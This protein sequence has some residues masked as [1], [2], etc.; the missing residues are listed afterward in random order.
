MEITRKKIAVVFGTRPDAVALAP[1]I[2]ELR[3]YPHAVSLLLINAA[4]Q[5]DALD[6]I[7]T[8]YSITPDYHVTVMGNRQSL[9]TLAQHILEKMDYLLAMEQPDMV[10]VR[11][12]AITA[13]VAGLA[14][15]HRKI[16]VVHVDAGLRSTDKLQPFPGEIYRRLTAQM[17]DLHC[18][19]TPA[20]AKAL[21]KEGIAKKS[22]VC[23]GNPAID[24]L[25]MTVKPRFEFTSPALTEV[26]A[27]KRRIIVVTTH[28]RENRGEP[29]LH[30]CAA[31]KELAEQ[32]P[33]ISIVFPVQGNAAV[34]DTIGP[35]LKET[36][37]IVLT[38]SLHYP[39]FINLIACSYAVITDS[40]GLQV[41]AP[42]LGKPVLLLRDRS[43]RTEA[44]K[45]G[46]V[47]L[48]GTG[49]KL[50]V[51]AADRIL[52]TPKAYRA[53]TRSVNPY[54]DGI[55]SG[56]IAAAVIRYFG[57]AHQKVKE[58]IPHD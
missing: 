17:T 4:Q 7:L 58:F 37:N 30:I 27:E 6:D 22:I 26:L 3:K 15:A 28:H 2:D 20:A 23:T 16:P 50:I 24:M 47:K 29:L 18:V 12:D 38:E 9:S 45:S 55:A 32:H 52:R 19:P 56:R 40:D 8:L 54:G 51:A 48:V 43:E 21:L 49:T 46:T 14:A 41:E 42:A 1:V 10:I 44:V 34:R 57:F 5:R 53:M 11:G 39:E 36:K 33:G 31:L 35:L 13:F 25:M